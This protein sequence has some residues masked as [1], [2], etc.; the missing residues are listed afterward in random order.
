MS[1]RELAER[2]A[3]L[4]PGMKVLYMSGHTDD[5]ILQHGVT[6]AGTGFLQKPFTPDVLERR[7]RELLGRA[8]SVAAPQPDSR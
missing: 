4:R 3:P 6:Q 5:A 7:I 2:L 8:G 1:G